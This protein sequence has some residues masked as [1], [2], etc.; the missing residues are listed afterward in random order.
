MA[1]VVSLRARACMHT[2]MVPQLAGKSRQNISSRHWR[3]GH[4]QRSPF[5]SQRGDEGEDRTYAARPHLE[6]RQQH[7][8][9]SSPPSPM[10]YEPHPVS[11]SQSR[12]GYSPQDP[13]IRKRRLTDEIYLVFLCKSIAA[14]PGRVRPSFA[15]ARRLRSTFGAVGSSRS[16]FPRYRSGHHWARS[17]TSVF[18]ALPGDLDGGH[19]RTSESGSPVSGSA[20]TTAGEAGQATGLHSPSLSSSNAPAADGTKAQEE[21]KTDTMIVV[22]PCTNCVR[23]G[24]I[25]C[26]SKRQLKRGPSKGYIKDLERRLDSLENH[27]SA[28]ATTAA[29]ATSH[30]GGPDSSESNQQGQKQAQQHEKPEERL[31]RLENALSATSKK[32][33]ASASPEVDHG[34]SSRNDGDEERELTEAYEIDEEEEDDFSN[35]TSLEAMPSGR[36]VTKD[37]RDDFARTDVGA[38]VPIVI[39]GSGETADR[40]L[41]HD[42]VVLVLSG[43]SPSPEHARSQAAKLER[44]I[45]QAITGSARA[46]PSEPMQSAVALRM[47]CEMNNTQRANEADALML[48]YLAGLCQGRAD[49]A[50][51]AAAASKLVVRDNSD[52]RRRTIAAI[53]DCWHTTAFNAPQQVSM[54]SANHSIESLV[55]TI[56]L[57][58]TS[59]MPGAA[60]ELLRCA[61]VISQL[62][63][64]LQSKQRSWEDISSGDVEVMFSNLGPAHVEDQPNNVSK[65]TVLRPLLRDAIRLY[66]RLHRQHSLFAAGG[67]DGD[68]NASLAASVAGLLYLV[69]GVCSIGSEDPS[70]ADSMQTLLR[71]FAGPHVLAIASVALAFISNYLAYSVAQAVYPSVSESVRSRNLSTLKHPQRRTHDLLQHLAS[72][73]LSAGR[74]DTGPFNFLYLRLTAFIRSTIDNIVELGDLTSVRT[75]ED[76]PKS[77]PARRGSFEQMESEALDFAR[78]IEELGPLGLVLCATSEQEAWGLLRNRSPR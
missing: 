29:P 52:L 7:R 76:L 20:S 62:R 35:E 58:E 31:I 19:K 32:L 66:H 42:A 2:C 15:P 5:W 16:R 33:Q 59:S 43:S 51:L 48:C 44:I 24:I 50:I 4:N 8:R 67:A 11:S 68:G 69:E 3:Q 39:S 21:P 10:H 26:Y 17:W 13:S 71:C 65:S 9:P 75:A 46:T 37:V 57:N 63:D 22:Q 45:G 34:T 72:I 14:S 18:G 1:R 23:S 70:M 25:C 77:S 54:P 28:T 64:M 38:C 73:T 61:F 41:L 53:L 47:G 55:A 40:A 30:T 6:Q 36:V 49:G 60:A 27:L 78:S 74:E 56:G 12:S